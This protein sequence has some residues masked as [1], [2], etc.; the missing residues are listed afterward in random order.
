MEAKVA[1]KILK[2]VYWDSLGKFQ[3]SKSFKIVDKF[4][5]KHT[6]NSENIVK[7]K[8]EVRKSY[9]GVCNYLKDE[10][11]YTKN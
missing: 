1:A 8:V 10:L 5:H 9:K 7:V 11:Q 2:G 3:Y 4:R 6:F